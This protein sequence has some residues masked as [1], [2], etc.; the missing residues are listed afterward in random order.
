MNSRLLLAPVA[1]VL[2]VGSAFAETLKVPSTTYPTIQSAVNAVSQGDV[3]EIKA[4]TYTQAILLDAAL[5]VTVRGK[6][7]VVIDAQGLSAGISVTDCSS[8][9]IE[10]IEVRGAGVGVFVSESAKVTLK[11]VK[12]IGALSNGFETVNGFALW[13]TQCVARDAGKHG[14]M[15]ETSQSCIRRCDA[16]DSAERGFELDGDMNVIAQC[17]VKGAVK[18]GIWM[19]DTGSTCD[20]NVIADNRISD[21][22]FVGI[23]T[24]DDGQGNAVRGNTVKNSLI[25]GI[26]IGQNGT[27]LA[28]N[29]VSKSVSHGYWIGAQYCT[30][31]NNKV[32]NAGGQ[33]F[34]MHAACDFCSLVGNSV[35]GAVG[36]G[37]ELRGNPMTFVKNTAKNCAGGEVL[38]APGALV[39][40]F[41]NGFA[42][43]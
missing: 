43:N 25:Y 6:G 17:K 32:K 2:S 28:D 33:G 18:E 22:G 40:A 16:I 27:V 37:F 36:V 8:A 31:Q 29:R 19:H 23:L 20:A 42:V 11:K 38:T 41:E 12:S 3:I 39:L 13:L 15:L 21:V 4:G 9:T 1:L 24:S 35:Q 34:F 30:I 14:F 5:G 10:N 7:K 26:E